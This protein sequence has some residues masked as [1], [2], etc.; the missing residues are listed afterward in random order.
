MDTK[1]CL[2]ASGPCSTAC[3]PADRMCL[4]S[5]G[6]LL[7][8]PVR[9][10]AVTV[11]GAADVVKQTFD[12]TLGGCDPCCTIPEIHC[13]DPCVAVICWTGCPG[14]Q[15]NHKLQITNTSKTSREFTL[16]PDPFVCTEESVTV[17]PDKKTLAHNEALQAT[18]SFKIP[19][20]FAGGIYQA[21]LRITGAYEQWI[22]VYVKVKPVQACCTHVEQGDIPR[23]VKAHH[24]YHHFQCEE[25]CYEAP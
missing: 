21:R 6:G 16:E 1:H 24:W 10:V 17:A 2:P 18:V 19:E 22:K 13:P 15:F 11:R 20:S 12:G 5:C 23:Q 9:L 7:L 8:L 3:A 4:P 25:A 14:D